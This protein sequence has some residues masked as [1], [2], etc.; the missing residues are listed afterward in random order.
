M[1]KRNLKKETDGD[2]YKMIL[3]D[4]NALEQLKKSLE[5]LTSFAYA[6]PNP[7]WSGI[8]DNN[9]ESKKLIDLTL[10]TIYKVLDDEKKGDKILDKILSEIIIGAYQ[11][12]M[13]VY[14]ISPS[15]V[16]KDSTE[17]LELI[18]KL[19]QKADLHLIRVIEEFKNIK[20]PSVQVIV[21]QADQVNVGEKQMNVDKQ[22][23]I[24]SD[25]DKK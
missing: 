19:R 24:S 6:H 18:Q 5:D 4:E 16:N 1:K 8:F 23:N 13:V 11:D 20:R 22:V 3:K 14:T 21:K 25:L 17:A 10:S 9:E 7:M 15:G 2:I 12:R